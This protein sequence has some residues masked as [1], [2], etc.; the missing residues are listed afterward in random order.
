MGQTTVLEI[1]APGCAAQEF[2]G[3]VV[4]LNLSNGI[5]CSF[6]DLGAVLWRDLAAGHSV[7]AM[8]ALLAPALGGAQA[9]QDFAARITAEGLMRPATGGAAPQ[10]QPQVIAALSGGIAPALT[11]EVFEDMKNLLLFDPVHEVDE[12]KGWPALPNGA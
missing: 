6:R 8:A 2:D 11:F 10:D 9:V 3:E 7:E 12:V 1:A 4:A 5:Y